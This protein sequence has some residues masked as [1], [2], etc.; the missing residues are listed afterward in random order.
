M[1]YIQDLAQALTLAEREPVQ[2]LSEEVLEKAFMSWIS[3]ELDTTEFQKFLESYG[4]E[5]Q[6]V[7]YRL[8]SDIPS[9]DTYT[10]WVDTLNEMN[11]YS[12]EHWELTGPFRFGAQGLENLPFKCFFLPFVSYLGSRLIKLQEFYKDSF[13]ITTDAKLDILKNFTNTLLNLCAPTLIAECSLRNISYSFFSQR[14]ESK[15]F[16]E[17]IFKKYPVLGRKVSETSNNFIN[18]IEFILRDIESDLPDLQRLGMISISK[19]HKINSIQLGLGDQHEGNRTVSIIYI[20]SKP[21]VYRPRSA[22]EFEL[23]RDFLHASS[24]SKDLPYPNF[25]NRSDHAWVEYIAQCHKEDICLKNHFYKMGILAAATYSLGSMDLHMENIVA[26]ASG[27][28]PIDLETILSSTLKK[29]T[30]EASQQAK[31]YLND[32]PLGTGI[33]PINVSIS[34]SNDMEVSALLGG[35][36]TTTGEYEEIVIKNDRV[37]IQKSKGETGH[38]KNIPE[39]LSIQDISENKEMVIKG[40]DYAIEMIANSPEEILFSIKRYENNYVRV[41]PRSTSLY[42]LMRRSLNH[43]KFMTSM[44]SSEKLLLSLWKTDGDSSSEKAIC[45]QAKIEAR[46]L[47]NGDIP[48]FE[49]KTNDTHIKHDGIVS[50]SL[51]GS[52][53]ERSRRRINK[54]R[55]R[56]YIQQQR[57]LIEEVLKASFAPNSLNNIPI[58]ESP[59]Y[60]YSSEVSVSDHILKEILHTISQKFLDSAFVSSKEA[61]WIGMVSS[62]SSESV[63][64]SPL[65]TGL[66][67][68]LAGVSLSL[69]QCSKVLEDEASAIY[70]K[71]ALS[72]VAHDLSKWNLNA[73][74]PIGALGGSSGLAYAVAM[75]ELYLESGSED[76]LQILFDF[77][78]K[79]REVVE[80]D[81]FYD[82]GSG[83]A[84]LISVL[85]SFIEADFPFQEECLQTLDKATSFLISQSEHNER[86]KG[87]Y[88]RSNNSSVPLGGYSHGTSGIAYALSRSGKHLNNENISESAISALSFDDNYF[89]NAQ[90]LWQDMR[91]ENGDTKVFPVHWC[92]GAAGIYLARA[93]S[94]PYLPQEE[95]IEFT[96]KAK[97]AL[98]NSS[99][100]GNDSLCHGS[101]G[102]A[103]CLYSAGDRVL[104]RQYLD[105]SMQR[106]LKSDFRHGL[107]LPVKN[108]PGLMLGYA[109][110][111]SSLCMALDDSLPSVLAFEAGKK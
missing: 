66:F 98:I 53:F 14:L 26:S 27:P 10:S 97:Y 77:V 54:F 52:P 35:V 103:V 25:F 96:N 32:S 81:I 99:L 94:Q 44:L 76:Y 83:A 60:N 61:T 51:S 62:E 22:P 91:T 73:E 31:D 88:W 9:T 90:G 63:R 48:R 93:L 45:L 20:D 18:S 58:Y 5:K 92:H 79:S 107:G 16:R 84:G 42:D 19:K 49:V 100:P 70:A 59:E 68:G 69:M 102:N 64:L 110:F 104:A 72:P 95:F 11:N 40:F 89:D 86:F 8:L 111:M 67:D 41:I 7:K 15:A 12:G 24:L 85:S 56:N 1:L 30:E 87:I 36:L 13:S 71:K 108:V 74:G 33:L 17:E 50:Q 65:G 78:K 37:F 3:P 46:N 57:S 34:G 2:N 109:G 28:V 101:L 43:P 23:Y 21:I 39:S 47:I 29:T 75:G 105:K 6:D 4:W 80:Q 38:T 82:L 55:E 106:I